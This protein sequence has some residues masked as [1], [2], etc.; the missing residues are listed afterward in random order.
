MSRLAHL[1]AVFSL[2][3]GKRGTIGLDFDLT[4]SVTQLPADWTVPVLQNIADAGYSGWSGSPNLRQNFPTS[5]A[6]NHVEA[7][8]YDIAVNPDPPPPFRRVPTLGPVTS[9]IL[10]VDGTETD[11]AVPPQVAVVVTFYT[12]IIAKRGRGRVYLPPLPEGQVG[13][14]GVIDGLWDTQLTANFEDW[15]LGIQ[16]SVPAGANCE[17]HVVSLTYNEFNPVTQRTVRSRVDTQ[18]RR[19]QRELA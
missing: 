11:N 6:L 14:D 12:A 19:L 8:A 17:H 7:Y 3:N 15:V 10:D 16:N 5:V 1:T 2:P 9:T 13:D 4:D 18:R